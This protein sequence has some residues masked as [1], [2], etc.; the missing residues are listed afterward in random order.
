MYNLDEEE[1][2]KQ[3]E[4]KEIQRQRDEYE[5]KSLPKWW[6]FGR[7]KIFPKYVDQMC[8]PNH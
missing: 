5:V 8:L 2:A 1:R 4:L 7:P 6:N 3:N